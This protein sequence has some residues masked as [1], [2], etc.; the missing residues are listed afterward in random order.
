[1][2]T[3]SEIK[4]FMLSNGSYGH[5]IDADAIK[6][7]K[8]DEAINFVLSQTDVDEDIVF[9][10]YT[11]GIYSNNS[12]VCGGKCIF[13]ITNKRIVYGAK[14]KLFSTIKSINASDCRDIKSDTFGLFTGT[15]YINTLTEI[16]KFPASKKQVLK[17][18]NMIDK[19]MKQIQS[20]SES[21]N[22]NSAPFSAADELKKYKELLYMGIITQEEFDAKKKQLLGL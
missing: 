13:L 10:L 16:I 1:M 8:F 11:T 6:N 3:L 20:S 12:I 21:R 18:A 2:K 19:A 4:E 9:A 7:G 15:I 22:S 5:D 17:L 14:D